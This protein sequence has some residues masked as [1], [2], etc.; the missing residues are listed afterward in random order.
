MNPLSVN[1]RVSMK[2]NFY[3][4]GRQRLCKPREQLRLPCGLGQP[5]A[6][7]WNHHTYSMISIYCVVVREPASGISSDGD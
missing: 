5:L 3:G 4:R 1:S 6:S 7:T 2:S